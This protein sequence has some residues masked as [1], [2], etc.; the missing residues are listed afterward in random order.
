MSSMNLGRAR[1][2]CG[3]SL[4]YLPLAECNFVRFEA[5]P[6][7]LDLRSCLRASWPALRDSGWN[8]F[9]FLAACCGFFVGAMCRSA[10]EPRRVDLRMIF[11]GRPGPT[12][13]A[14]TSV[15]QN[16][17]TGALDSIRRTTCT[18]LHYTGRPFMHK[19]EH[20]RST[21]ARLLASLA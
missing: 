15:L 12:T 13:S 16:P 20:H 14:C 7:S 2:W 5:C 1:G 19:L 3:R 9:S 18:T 10:R 8:T 6:A 4:N 11:S 17:T 21:L